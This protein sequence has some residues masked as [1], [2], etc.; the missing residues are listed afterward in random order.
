MYILHYNYSSH[1]NC[2]EWKRFRDEM[3]HSL[4][5]S[6][7]QWTTSGSTPS[8]NPVRQ[9]NTLNEQLNSSGEPQSEEY[10]PALLASLNKQT[11]M[12]ITREQI[13]SIPTQERRVG[14]CYSIHH[15]VISLPGHGCPGVLSATHRLH[16]D[17]R[18]QL[19]SYAT[20]ALTQ[21]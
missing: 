5:R 1:E 11:A 19:M 3:H 18:I 16:T 9:P 2:P 21:Q 20:T 7:E 15:Q 10:P 6:V 14:N 12:V 4:W 13:G 17:G 8:W